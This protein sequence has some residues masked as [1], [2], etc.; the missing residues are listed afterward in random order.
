M[1]DKPIAKKPEPNAIPPHQLLGKLEQQLPAA[2][3]AKVTEF[4][5]FSK[6]TSV[7]QALED[8]KIHRDKFMESCEKAKVPDTGDLARDLII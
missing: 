7:H 3:K 2:Q 8:L 4:Q 6:N 5:T 1:D